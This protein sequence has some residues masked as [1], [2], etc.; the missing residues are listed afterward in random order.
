MGRARTGG[1]DGRGLAASELLA[2]PEVPRRRV[3]FDP[4]SC[5]HGDFFDTVWAGHELT[6]PNLF[7]SVQYSRQFGIFF[8][9]EI[10]EILTQ[11]NV[12]TELFGQLVN[13]HVHQ[14]QFVAT[15][16][17]LCD[18]EIITYVPSTVVFVG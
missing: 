7:R 9:T 11:I 10:E 17:R 2:A 14:R 1:E 5:K 18:L 3:Q 8:E 6:T 12:E 16:T 13:Q 4:A 15:L